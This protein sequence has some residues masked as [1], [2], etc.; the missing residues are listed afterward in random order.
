MSVATRNPRAHIKVSD[1][2]CGTP[3]PNLRLPLRP[4]SESESKE[5]GYSSNPESQFNNTDT[6]SQSKQLTV[7]RIHSRVRSTGHTL[8]PRCNDLSTSMAADY[9]IFLR[10][11]LPSNSCPSN[12]KNRPSSH[13]VP[14]LSHAISECSYTQRLPS[15]EPHTPTGYLSPGPPSDTTSVP[16][17]KVKS[18]PATVITNTLEELRDESTDRDNY[19][20]GF[21]SLDEENLHFSLSEAV[22]I[23]VE[24]LFAESHQNLW[25]EA[26]GPLVIEDDEVVQ[27]MKSMLSLYQRM[28]HLSFSIPS[29]IPTEIAPFSESPLSLDERPVTNSPI[30]DCHL[31]NGARTIGSNWDSLSLQL[32]SS[33]ADLLSQ[34]ILKRAVVNNVLG[35]LDWLVDR[36]EAPQS[37]LPL[38]HR[39]LSE[40]ASSKPFPSPRAPVHI[41]HGSTR[42]RGNYQ[43]A[44]PRPQILFSIQPTPS[45]D[46]AMLQQSFLCAGCGMHIER[47]FYKSLNLCHYYNKYFCQTCMAQRPICIPA[48]ILNSWDF[49]RYSV[50]SIASNLLNRIATEP[51]FNVIVINHGLYKRVKTLHKVYLKRFQLCHMFHYIH[52]CKKAGKFVSMFDTHTYWA[53]DIHLYSLADL[54]QLRDGMLLQALDRLAVDCRNHIINCFSCRGKGFICEYCRHSEPVFPFDLFTVTRCK[55]CRACYH[56]RCYNYN[57]CP[58]CIR[59]LHRS[60]VT[61]PIS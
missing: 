21:S 5:S 18:I 45:L 10:L 7:K 57:T 55:E 52:S 28:P 27:D 51:L 1:G 43:W 19:L 35:S 59:L 4:H 33:S 38:P 48:Y 37:L 41:T 44:P 6:S 29:A 60:S 15:T 36:T 39:L 12:Y 54:Y 30:S 3:D 42:L 24:E 26:E 50:S 25:D 40:H 20:S 16:Q 58:K 13:P 22:L 46:Q 14:V 56:C 8:L 23:C 34:T 49:K 31:P 32:P 9:K 11:N 47:S 53:T 61:E 2:R 17:Q